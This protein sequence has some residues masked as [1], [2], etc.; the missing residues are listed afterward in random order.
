VEKR[1]RAHFVVDT[2][3]GFDLAREKVRYI[4]SELRRPGWRE[5]LAVGAEQRQ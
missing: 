5:R 2:G 1:A 4:I 3:R